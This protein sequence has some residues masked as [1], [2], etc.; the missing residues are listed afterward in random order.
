M[1]ALIVIQ[2]RMG[3]TRLP[4][5]VLA[6][7]GGHS[8][9]ALLCKR[10]RRARKADRIVLATTRLPSD[11]QLEL[12]GH[13]LSIPVIRGDE[14]NLITRFILAL[15]TF[16]AQIIV[17]VTA[18][19]PFTDPQLL[20]RIVTMVEQQG[21]DYA[22]A[23]GA[24]VGTSVDAYSAAALRRT[25]AEASTAYQQEHLNA[26]VLDNPSLF[27][28]GCVPLSPTEQRPDIHVTVDTAEDL[29][30]VRR[31]ARLLPDPMLASLSDIIN[32]YDQSA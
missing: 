25:A 7:I 27:Q 26:F 17:R 22:H 10:L 14:C 8:L 3:S 21:M 29:R 30:R 9:L 32:A 4:G 12:V 6:D 23:P 24:P 13:Q 15:Q 19:N 20:D 1:S 31:V 11:D 18:D 28:I 16:P 5:K 2:A